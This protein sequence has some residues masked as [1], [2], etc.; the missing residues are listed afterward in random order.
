MKQLLREGS[1][2]F[3]IRSFQQ[4]GRIMGLLAC[5]EAG[6][7]TPKI[8][9]AL[10]QAGAIIAE[11]DEV[12]WNCLFH[13]VLNSHMFWH[14]KE[15]EALKYLLNVFDDIF[16][17]DTGG[18]SIFDHVAQSRVHRREFFA[19]HYGS[20]IQDLWYCAL[21]RSGLSLRL[22]IPP[23]PLGPIFDECYTPRHYRALLYLNTWGS[24]DHDVSPPFDSVEQDAHIQAQRDTAPGAG[25]WQTSDLLMMEERINSA[26]YFSGDSIHEIPSSGD[27]SNEWGPE[28][29]LEQEGDEDDE[30]DDKEEGEDEETSHPTLVI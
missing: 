28:E 23:P 26:I 20:Y 8:L 21:Y 14:S 27:S 19:G 30:Q 25:E 15:F 22:K 18:L 7:T 16:A 17:C 12:G 2:F 11:V 1:S 29:E 3:E 9:Q 4:F 24:M 10:V 6:R 5:S 13:C